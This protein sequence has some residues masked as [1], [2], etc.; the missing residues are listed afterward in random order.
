MTQFPFFFVF[1]LFFLSFFFFSFLSF[2]ALGFLLE[3]V[4]VSSNNTTGPPPIPSPLNSINSSGTSCCDSVSGGGGA[5]T[6]GLGGRGLGLG[7]SLRAFL[8]SLA[9]TSACAD[10]STLGTLLLRI[11]QISCSPF[12]YISGNRSTSSFT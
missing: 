1:L 10:G 4:T 5:C 6:L 7:R 12:D 3:K 11:K 2:L 9:F 8:Q